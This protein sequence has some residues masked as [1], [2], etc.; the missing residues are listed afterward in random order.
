MATEKFDD[1]WYPGEA[2]TATEFIAKG[3]VTA[4]KITV[5]YRSLEARDVARR[6]GM[7]HGM[8]A[9]F[10]RLEELLS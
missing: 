3:D 4:I 9:G 6:S 10:N 8:A 2:L 5:L 1:S 7:E